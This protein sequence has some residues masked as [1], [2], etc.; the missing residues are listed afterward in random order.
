MVFLSSKNIISTRS[1]KKLDDKRYNSFKIKALVGLLYR[2][3]L[4]K[5]IRIYNVFYIKL[6]TL[7]ITNSLLGQKNFLS[8]PT[9]VNDIEE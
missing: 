9:M 4:P 5:T 2:L 7:A 6:L 3:E 8:K 1:S